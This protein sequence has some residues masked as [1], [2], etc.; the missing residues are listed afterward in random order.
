MKDF[1]K[2]A[3]MVNEQVSNSKWDNK[4]VLK[5]EH[6]GFNPLH[7]VASGRNNVSKM[8]ELQTILTEATE[9]HFETEAR[10][11]AINIYINSQVQVDHGFGRYKGI[12]LR[13]KDARGKY[14]SMTLKNAW[15][16][17][18]IQVNR[19][20]RVLGAEAIVKANEGPFNEFVKEEKAKVVTLLGAKEEEPGQTEWVMRRMREQF[21][22]QFLQE[23]V[24]LDVMSS[25]RR[26]L[27]ELCAACNVGIV[28]MFEFT[29]QFSVWNVQFLNVGAR[30]LEI[31]WT[32]SNTYNSLPESLKITLTKDIP[33][34]G[35]SDLGI[36]GAGY[37]S[38]DDKMYIPSSQVKAAKAFASKFRAKRMNS[39][40]VA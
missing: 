27:E 25:S 9:V 10:S 32:K 34:V 7:R 28:R 39:R 40:K 29:Q 20:L 35:L 3:K 4:R 2:F 12:F 33:A 24:N 1:Q 13:L 19:L 22:E 30:S 16:R 11:S 21:A 5:V 31:G 26:W 23:L 14:H 6:T 18:D 37:Y 15:E 17:K 38:H 36:E 8:L